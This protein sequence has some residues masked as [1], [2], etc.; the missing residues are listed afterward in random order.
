M[1]HRGDAENAEK[2]ENSD[3]QALTL[4]W[5]LEYLNLET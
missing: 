2:T 4:Y 1:A 3:Y 5:A